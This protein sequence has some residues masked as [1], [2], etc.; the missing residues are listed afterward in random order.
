MKRHVSFIHTSPAAI[1]P[2]A[3]YYHLYAQDLEITNLLDDGILRCFAR[4]MESAAETRFS[5]LLCVARDAYNSELALVTC[6]AVSR[7]VMRRLADA[8][9]LPIVKIDDALAHQ[10]VTTGSKLGVLVTFPPT[11][12]V[13][14]KLLRDTAADNGVEVDLTFRV[15]PEAYEALLAGQAERHDELMMNAVRELAEKPLDAIVFAQVSM[16]R[17]LPKLPHLPMPVLSSL[18]AS[19]SAI[20]QAL[21][22]I[23]SR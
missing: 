4:Q 19:L 13:T 11:Q 7:S 12:A 16:A 22:A 17:L 2:L 9:G 18:P 20:R 1:P 23:A 6:S 15:L 5:E 3:D 8:T 21:P 10:A 14:A